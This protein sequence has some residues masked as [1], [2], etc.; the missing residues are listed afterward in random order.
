MLKRI[1]ENKKQAGAFK[2]QDD[3]FSENDDDIY[4]WSIDINLITDVKL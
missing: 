1:Q 2:K 4:D 3:N